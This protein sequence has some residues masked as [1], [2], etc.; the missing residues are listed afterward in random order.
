VVRARSWRTLGGTIGWAVSCV[1]AA[2]VLV[3]AGYAHYVQRQVGGLASSNVDTGGPQT[4]AMNILLMGLESRTDYNGNILPAKLLAALHAGSVRGVEFEGV[5]GQDTNTLI[6]IHIF[7]GGQKA[8]GFSIPRDDLVTFPQP[9]DGESQGK[10]DQ[11]YGLA[12]AQSL[13]ETVNS[14]MSHNQRY[15]LANEA[16]QA[17]AI[18]TVSAVT[19]EHI[20]HFAEVNL[21]GFYALAQAFHGIEVCVKS[22][23]GG[24]NLHDTNSGFS[25]PHAGYLH[26]GAAQALSF[27]R[28][29]DN[30]PNGDLD[31]THRQQAVIDYVLW[32]LGHQGALTDLGQLTNLLGVA[33]KYLIASGGW[34]LLEF[35]NEMHALTGKNLTLGTLPIQTTQNGVLVNGV[36]QDVDIVNLPYARH[37]V[38]S[39][40]S[41]PP[42][43]QATGPAA[44]KKPASARSIPPPSTVTVDVYN[45][46]TTDLLAAAVSQALVSAGYKAGSTGSPT[47]QAQ[48]VQASTQVFYGTGASA[49]AAKIA[50]YFGA[51]A[52]AARAVAAG[53]VEVLL[54]T[55]STSVPVGIGPSSSGSAAATPTATSAVNN[56]QA[57]GAVTVKGNAPFGIPCEY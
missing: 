38:Q 46:G 40:F 35:A 17:A 16:G 57:G 33:R 14:K 31:R 42:A 30:L 56:G 32:Q 47:A 44:K 19:G 52:T 18:A 7:A 21:A 13:N 29:R 6:L 10:I 55:T 22:W 45:G 5:G 54:G 15:F 49:N 24:R 48:T 23:D 2:V 41:Q 36:P 1:L 28:E 37:L 53:H 9:Y 11:A 12:W 51:T 43:D 26:L 4:G 50:K 39:M 34:N 3:I 25:Q 27:V 8:V 20:D